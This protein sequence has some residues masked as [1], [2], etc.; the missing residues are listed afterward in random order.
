MT[1]TEFN[2]TNSTSG[3]ITQAGIGFT[4]GTGA[5]NCKVAYNVS[6]GKKTNGFFQFPTESLPESIQVTR[7]EFFYVESLTQPVTPP[8][9]MNVYIGSFI[10]TA[11]DGNISEFNSGTFMI[12]AVLEGWIVNDQTYYD[13]A[14]AGNDPTGFV[15]TTSPTDIR[16]EHNTAAGTNGRDFNSLKV[17]CKLRVTYEGIASP[18]LAIA[19]LIINSPV[20]ITSKSSVVSPSSVSVS[21][22]LNI[23]VVSVSRSHIANPSIVTVNV[24]INSPAASISRNSTAETQ[25]GIITLTINSP[26]VSI[27]K[28]SLVHVDLGIIAIEINSPNIM[29][30]RNEITETTTIYASVIINSPLVSVVNFVSLRNI[31]LKSFADKDSVLESRVG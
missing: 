16:F 29:I 14:D 2:F 8:D 10:G 24:V 23:P 22:L 25:T 28:S 19:K 7:V 30:I 1:Q 17:K 21:L 18:S 5:N 11:L 20:V 4:V 15:N 9:V 27:I 13:L 26:A 6:T 31:L 3:F 12:D